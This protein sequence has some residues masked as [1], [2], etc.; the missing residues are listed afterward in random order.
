M[1]R[2]DGKKPDSVFGG[3]CHFEPVANNARIGHQ[4]SVVLGGKPG[5][6]CGVK[7]SERLPVPVSTPQN[8]S[9]TESGLGTFQDEELEQYAIVANGDAPFAVVVLGIEGVIGGNP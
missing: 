3:A 9:P 1:F 5:Y 8:G 7:L 2:L 6:G 4:A